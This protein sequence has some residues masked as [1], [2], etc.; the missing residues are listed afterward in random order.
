[1]NVRLINSKNEFEALE[2]VWNDLLCRSNS[3]HINLT[4]EWMKTWFDVYGGNKNLFILMAEDNDGIAGISPLMIQNINSPYHKLLNVKRLT[5]MASGISDNLDF[6]IVRKNELVINEFFDF[7]FKNKNLWDE[8]ILCDI[9]SNSSN[10]HFIK[11]YTPPTSFI[12]N[13][14]QPYNGYYVSSSAS[15]FNEYY[16]SLS[17][18][19][20]RAIKKRSRRLRNDFTI[21]NTISQDVSDELI[22][23]IQNFE[24]KRKR[25]KILRG[26]EQFFKTDFVNFLKNLSKNFKNQKWLR[27]FK[28]LVNEKLAAYV[29]SFDYNQKIYAWLTSYN[30]VFYKYSVGL[31]IHKNAIEFAFNNNY[32]YFDFMRGDETYKKFFCKERYLYYSISFTKI[33]AKMTINRAINL[34]RKVGGK[35]LRLLKK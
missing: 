9:D 24:K 33:N 15:N 1:M 31:L 12:K 23:D 13:I 25:Y 7:I 32:K 27:I 16:S 6:I 2:S 19:Q 3:N 28:I 10:L 14:L 35:L 17:K 5:F 8:L 30:L 4:F 18:E 20:R 11:K 21:K 22:N 29:I 26:S 34:S